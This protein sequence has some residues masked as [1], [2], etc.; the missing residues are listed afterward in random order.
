LA[1]AFSTC[2]TLSQLAAVFV[3]LGR[4]WE[5]AHVTPHN[6][7]PVARLSESVTF[8]VRTNSALPVPVAAVTA[9]HSNIA[10][11]RRSAPSV[12]P[13]ARRPGMTDT[14]ASTIGHAPAATAFVTGRDL[15]LMPTQMPRGPSI[16]PIYGRDPFMPAAPMSRA[17]RDSALDAL[18]GAMP[19]LLGAYV[20]KQAD[21]DSVLK[22]TNLAMRL[23]GR[24]L[25]VP[26]DPHL[27]ADFSVDAPLGSHGPS[28]AERQRDSVSFAENRRRLERLQARVR[29]RIDSLRVAD[30]LA[31]H[32]A[33]P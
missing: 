9:G 15:R 3:L 17:T 7:L 1:L 10:S 4:L 6:K 25:L 32:L 11:V 12:I 29:A 2:A 21:R 30:S 28:R 27:I 8:V 23:A 19:S 24:P 31:R 5:P 18:N 33:A 14:A 26:P 22:V 16:G 20:M 13:K